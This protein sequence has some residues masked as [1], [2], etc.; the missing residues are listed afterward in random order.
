[1]KPVKLVFKING[2]FM[3]RFVVLGQRGTQ[4]GDELT[5]ILKLNQL[6]LVPHLS[7]GG[8]SVI[9]CVED[10]K[11]FHFTIKLFKKKKNTDF[12]F[13]KAG[14]AFSCPL[15]TENHYL[16]DVRPGRV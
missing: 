5:I 8:C 14:F 13:G 15:K 7:V 16:S 1:M 2:K 6:L 10:G 11:I 4:I 9:S 12:I 3:R